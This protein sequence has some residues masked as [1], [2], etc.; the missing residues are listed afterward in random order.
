MP[1]RGTFLR[2]T[3]LLGEERTFGE[4]SVELPHALD[5]RGRESTTKAFRQPRGQPLDELIP[6]LRALFTLLLDLDDLAADEPIDVD[7][8]CVD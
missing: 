1:R 2:A 4:G 3:H 8:S 5:I 6:I 7:G